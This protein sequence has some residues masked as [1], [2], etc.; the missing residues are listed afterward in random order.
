MMEAAGLSTAFNAK[1]CVRER[2]DVMIA[3]DDLREILPHINRFKEMK[4]EVFPTLQWVTHQI[5]TVEIKRSDY[6]TLG[7]ISARFI[8]HSKFDDRLSIQEM[9]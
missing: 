4:E 8:I 1:S 2:A 7:S 9:S 3:G 5:K 6:R